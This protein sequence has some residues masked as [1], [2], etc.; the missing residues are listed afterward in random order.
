MGGAGHVT[1][2]RIFKADITLGSAR[3][4]GRRF[5]G[6]PAGEPALLGLDILSGFD[7]QVVPGQR[8][9]LRPRGDLRATASE[10]IRRWPWIPTCPSPSCVQARIAL[11]GTGVRLDLM[12]E[13]QLPRAVELVLACAESAIAH[14]VF[15]ATAPTKPVNGHGPPSLSIIVDLPSTKPGPV[16]VDV[17]AQGKHWFT[18]DGAGCRDLAVIDVVPA[19]PDRLPSARTY[20]RISP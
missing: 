19:V 7:L 10:R 18:R 15:M 3:F 2:A 20:A 6:L 13:A 17:S 4:E 1:V 16:S 5:I 9:L 12:I 14:D 11:L 8:L